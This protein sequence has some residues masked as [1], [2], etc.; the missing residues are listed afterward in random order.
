MKTRVAGGIVLG[1]WMWLGAGAVASAMTWGEWEASIPDSVI[2]V[3]FHQLFE[4]R[5]YVS[6]D[7][8][9][10][11]IKSYGYIGY[12]EF[13]ADEDAA[14]SPQGPFSIRLSYSPVH[15]QH[16][17][18]PQENK[19]PRGF[20]PTPLPKAPMQ[21][22]L[23]IIEFTDFDSLPIRIPVDLPKGDVRGY[24][25]GHATMPGAI[26]PVYE[27]RDAT[28][29]VLCRGRM[30]ACNSRIQER[31]NTL[32]GS[33]DI[34]DTLRRALENT[35]QEKI[36]R[37]PE[38]TEAYN[39]ISY[40]WFT[41]D[42]LAS[43]EGRE[44]FLRRLLLLGINFQGAAEDVAA[45]REKLGGTRTGWIF[46]GGFGKAAPSKTTRVNMLDNLE[47]RTCDSDDAECRT[48]PR[49]LLDNEGLVFQPDRRAYQNWTVACLLVFTLGCCVILFLVFAR[50]R[51]EQRIVVWVGLPVWSVLAA[52]LFY[53]GGLLVLNRNAK[54]DVTEYRLGVAGWPEM[55][56]HAV[57]HTMSYTGGRAAFELPRG[58]WSGSIFPHEHRLDG[59]WQRHDEVRSPERLQ[60]R[61]NRTQGGD[62]NVWVY[63]WFEEAALPLVKETE[64]ESGAVIGFRLTE[65][66]DGVWL[67]ADGKWLQFNAT[68]AGEYI[69][70]ELGYEIHALYGL[71]KRLDSALHW[72]QSENKRCTDPTHNH[73]IPEEPEPAIHI[74]KH[75]P[76]TVVLK[77][78]TTPRVKAD[79]Q[80]PLDEKGRVVW[81]TQWP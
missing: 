67:F 27:L 43:M 57:I 11:L 29:R 78:N 20:I 33:G 16:L 9:D 35:K 23:K 25:T 28:G 1:L 40:I 13:T 72:R 61:L 22:N 7:T 14:K 77:K 70:P 47:L 59:Y 8:A 24:W 2:Q 19:I 49:S 41:P 53:A 75:D 80:Q 46:N 6:Y 76:V 36:E 21:P 10:A 71:P 54:L 42:L 64:S 18:W 69:Y 66:V 48:K 65:D 52:I 37:L 26:F 68:K 34:D 32:V 4:K 63:F 5:E 12:L 15:G 51:G 17:D 58:T 60:C 62:A 3:E 74:P 56:C 39:D 45:L 30:N 79:W 81:I 50:R 38:Y 31:L 73:P 44:D 55:Y